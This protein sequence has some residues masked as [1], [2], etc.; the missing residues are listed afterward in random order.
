MNSFKKFITAVAVGL[1]VLPAIAAGTPSQKYGS[2]VNTLKFRHER[3]QPEGL[4][5]VPSENKISKVPVRRSTS[6]R[7]ELVAN[8]LT[9]KPGYGMYSFYAESGLSMQKL[10]DIPAFY[11][12][13]VYVNGKYYGADY[14]TDANSQ[15]TYVRWYVYDAQTWQREKMVENP[16]DLTYIA[17]DRTYDATTGTVYSIVYDKTG[18]SIQLATTSLNDGASTPIGKLEKDVITLTADDKGQLYG[19]D[20][21]AN[22]YRI[23]KSNAALTLVGST[24]IF[25]EYLSEYPQSIAYDPE[26]KKILWAEF[27][28]SGLFSV[29]AA[30]YEV[31]PSNASTVKIADIP[32]SPELIGMYVTDYIAPD[33]PTAVTGLTITPASAG[34]LDYTIAFTAP[35]TTTDG[36]AITGTMTIEISIDGDLMDIK[37]A[38]AGQ[39]VTCDPFT[40]TRGLHTVKIT[41]ENA[42]GSG[43]VMAR[44]F[45][46]GYDVPSAPTGV[47]LKYEN[48]NAT[49]SWK[50]PTEGAEGGIIRTPLTYDVVRMPGNVK[51]ADRISA[52]SFSEPISQAARYYYII[53]PYSAEGKGVAAESN[54][55]V[56]G[57][58]SVPFITS[59][60]T[61][62]EFDLWTTVD[63]TSGGKVWNYDEENHRLRHPWSIDNMMDDY[64]VSPPIKMDASKSYSVSFDAY[65]MV[66]SYNEHVMLYFGPSADISKMTLILD[67]EKLPVDAK[68]FEATVAPAASGNS[69][70]AFRSTAPRNGFMSY[71]DNVSITEKGS[72]NVAATVD[73]LVAK[74]ADN[75][76]LKVN[77]SFT[78][79]TKTMQGTAL[80]GISHIDIIRGESTEPIKT[81]E[82]PVPGSQ[83]TWTDTSVKTGKYTYRVVVYTSAGAGE[84]S[85]ATAFA[86]I[87]TPESPTDL[88][89]TGNEGRRIISWKA[90]A[91]GVNGGNLTGVLSY[92]LVRMVNDNEQVIDENLTAAE[93]TDTWTT[94]EQAFVYYAVSAVTSAGSSNAIN[95]RS[96]AVGDPYDLPY[97]ESFAG[98]KPQTN[99]WAI[100]QVT[101]AQGEWAINT[102]GENP[103]TA[104]QDG[105]DGLATFDGYHGWTDGVELRLISPT[106]GIR[107]YKDV[108]LSFYIYHYNGTAGWWQETPDPVGESMIVEVSEDG[109]PFTAIPEASYK[110]YDSKS[111]WKK[112]EISLD[113]YRKTR[114]IRVAFRGKGAGNFNIHLDN[115]AIDGI[116]DSTAAD[117]IEN[118]SAYVYGDRGMIRFG[119]LQGEVNVYDI[120]G[121]HIARVNSHEGMVSVSAGIY[122]VVCG[123][124]TFKV[125]VK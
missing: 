95:S 76:E 36:S 125:I 78:A 75:G 18:N 38:S 48:G 35:S 30:L 85:V 106:I 110:L 43:A 102:K 57:S 46:A 64:I 66:E 118:A 104:A 80:S 122:A 50:A 31:N 23:N 81:F 120:A 19:I 92:R 21:S 97:H 107:I 42:A 82:N 111:A 101:G 55:L 44:V 99:P 45:F 41:A 3:I 121:R 34:S 71:V 7:T 73:N 105:D 29:A 67:T 28:T 1:I 27:H 2:R 52:T 69:F 91:Q 39:K 9:S 119:G 88:N 12:G 11:G 112:Y 60:D 24:N 49:V 63:V 114:G 15:L 51:V 113:N 54:S 83:L 20:T 53:T 109:A 89:V 5:A 93:Y 90:P 59:F 70:I 6:G 68:T 26:S 13:A 37:E 14:D 8:C 56:A 124:V 86:G 87:D 22:L 10:A 123:N 16:L 115:I 77:L 40:F 47:T 61:Q 72:S 100:E 96:F 74:G 84:P 58:C 17:T 25:E 103:Y 108:K 116:Y 98:G 79:P 62:A 94:H 4:Y 33:V 65:Q 117:E 32:G